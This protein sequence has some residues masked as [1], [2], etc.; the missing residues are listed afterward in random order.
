MSHP[1]IADLSEGSFHSDIAPCPSRDLGGTR[2]AP[3]TVDRGSYSFSRRSRVN[4]PN[5]EQIRSQYPLVEKGGYFNTASFGAISKSTAAV[6]QADIDEL[7]YTG[8]RNYEQWVANYFELKTVLAEYLSCRERNMAFFPD[9]SNGINKVSELLSR[10]D[11]VILIRDD[12]PSVTL[13]WITRNYK[14]AWIDY[15]DFVADYLTEIERRLKKGAKIL[16]LSLVFFNHGFRIDPKKVGKLCRKYDCKFILDATQGLG[17]FPIDTTGSHIDFMVSSCFK[18]FMAGYGVSIGYVS[19]TILKEFEINQSGWQIL[20]N[21]TKNPEKKKNY[22]SDASRF[23]LGHLKFQNL[24]MLLESLREMKSIGFEN[25]T[26][27]TMEL[28]RL[29]GSQLSD[30]GIETFTSASPLP[31]GILAIKSKKRYLKNLEGAG[32]VFSPRKNYIR[33]SSYFYNSEEDIEALV[34][35]LKR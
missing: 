30:I 23:E 32:I 4:T 13:P 25:I 7:L 33:F 20:K 16:C 9:S 3:E 28:T 31:S 6:A 35:L 19:D 34:N 27:R 17:A 11:E 24:N 10:K 22:K 18:W 5:W 29:L 21:Y 26:N 14:I 1:P 2:T 12:F 15:Q 8:A